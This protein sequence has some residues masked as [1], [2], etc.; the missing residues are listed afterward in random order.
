MLGA[1]ESRL[2]RNR[3]SRGDRYCLRA[4]RCTVACAYLHHTVQ[5]DRERHVDLRRS[6]RQRLDSVEVESSERI[7]GAGNVGLALHDVHL[8]ARLAVG[9][10]R[11]RAHGFGRDRRVARNDD[12]GLAVVRFDAEGQRRHVEENESLDL[13]AE[14]SGLDRGAE[15]DDFVRVDGFVRLFAKELFDHFLNFWN[16]QQ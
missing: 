10:R 12:G 8:D 13:A 7:V 2:A 15:R 4:S 5:V 14:H 16:K 6:G 9:C 1:A 3:S 11:E